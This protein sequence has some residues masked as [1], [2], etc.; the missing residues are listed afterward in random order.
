MRENHGTVIVTG[1]SRGIGKEISLELVRRGYKTAVLY[2]GNVAAAEELKNEASKMGGTAEIF[3]VSV[4]NYEEVAQCFRQVEE[5]LGPVYG[6]VNNA[7]ITRDAFLM[8]MKKDDWSRVLE[9]NLLG[10]LNCAHAILGH[11]SQNGGGR[12][13]NI[14]SVG[15]VLGTASQANYS[16]SK[17]AVLG[18]TRAL[19]AELISKGIYVYG[20]A[21]GYIETEMLG[22]I[23]AKLLEQY[24]GSI[25]MKAFGKVDVISRVVMELLEDTFSYTTGQTFILDGGLCLC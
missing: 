24:R 5:K 22:T 9:T 19:A 21:P 4:E 20:I 25:P 14:S 2:K 11:M 13:I 23:P 7:G 8:L 3:K 18:F 17:A 1:S 12:I 16:A 15:G 10:V 6:L